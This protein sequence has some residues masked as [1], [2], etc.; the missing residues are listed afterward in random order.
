MYICFSKVAF[1][2]TLYDPSNETV[3]MFERGVG[4][5]DLQFLK[6]ST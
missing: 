6:L 2:I 3:C 1:S 5:V 4:L